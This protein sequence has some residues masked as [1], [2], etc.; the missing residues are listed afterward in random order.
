MS[1]S[2]EPN[3][4]VHRAGRVR[5][6]AWRRVARGLH[7]R[8]DAPDPL[9]VELTAW[10]TTLPPESCFTGLTAARLRGWELP[11]LP[12]A[13]PVC[14]AVRTRDPHPVRPG[15]LVTRHR[16]RPAYDV[17][18]GLRVATPAEIIVWCAR[19]L[20]VLDLVVLI[21]TALRHGMRRED[22]VVAARQRRRGVPRLR[23][24]LRL[25]DPRAESIWETLRRLLHVVCG[26]EVEPQTPIVVDGTEIGR[27]DLW[28]VGSA[29]LQE[30]DG[31]HHLD[32]VQFARDRRRDRLILD[33]GF[34]RNGYTARDLTE[35]AAA[36][37][38]DA[39]AALGNEGD[40][41][42]IRDWYALMRPSLFSSA[43]RAD[44]G[45]RWSQ[46]AQGR[47][48]RRKPS[49]G[50]PAVAPHDIEEQRPAS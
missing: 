28:I 9:L 36:V 48:S 18:G 17:I 40:P 38:R 45:R 22:L 29:T 8:R 41:A 46:A 3:P 23:E 12:E 32:A 11:P 21:D 37:L 14:A 27:A 44:V 5:L 24:A 35:R 2:D 6:E 20:E 49:S 1:R 10:Q 39:D 47:A 42:R 25:S 7:V 43:G 50:Q 4:P 15:M 19:W 31:A 34:R 30:Y 16:G 33:G 26:I 13:M